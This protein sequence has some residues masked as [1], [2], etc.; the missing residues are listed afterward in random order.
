MG[1]SARLEDADD[2]VL[3]GERLLHGLQRDVLLAHLAVAGAVEPGRL[4][5]VYLNGRAGRH[6]TGDGAGHPS[7]ITLPRCVTL[8]T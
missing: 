3:A 8:R 6:H 2:P 5:V 7:H 4:L 1:H